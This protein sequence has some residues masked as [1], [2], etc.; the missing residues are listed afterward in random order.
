MHYPH[1]DNAAL[2][3]DGKVLAFGGGVNGRSAEVSDPVTGQWALVGD[4][5]QGFNTPH[6]V[7]TLLNGDIFVAGACTGPA[8]IFTCP[9]EL[10]ALGTC[11]PGLDPGFKFPWDASRKLAYTG[12]PHDWSTPTRSGL[13]FSA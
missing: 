2:L 9:P 12:G 11:Q 6:G 13:D 4:M 7:V 1:G 8:E 10:V 3:S 5:H